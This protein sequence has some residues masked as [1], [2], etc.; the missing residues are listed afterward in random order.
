MKNL[1]NIIFILCFAGVIVGCQSQSKQVHGTLSASEILNKA[2]QTYSTEEADHKINALEVEY[3]AAVSEGKN[4]SHSKETIKLYRKKPDHYKYISIVHTYTLA[5]KLDI[6]TFKMIINGDK[7]NVSYEATNPDSSVLGKS[8]V[9]RLEENIIN[10]RMNLSLGIYQDFLSKKLYPG[11]YKI[12]GYKC[13]KIKVVL[14]KKL[15]DISDI[16]LTYYIDAKTFLVHEV[17]G[18]DFKVTDIKYR[19]LGSRM[20]P[21][22]YTEKGTSFFNKRTAYFK[23]NKY[24]VNPKFEENFFS[25]KSEEEKKQQKQ[26]KK[27]KYLTNI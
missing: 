6:S 11:F 9:N 19:K 1:A 12:N 7:V 14:D 5:K 2:K 21:E 16:E 18:G 25:T 27:G 4:K 24:V 13:Y 22:S 26:E 15:K 3:Q 23:L 20:I 17:D 10:Y 8:L